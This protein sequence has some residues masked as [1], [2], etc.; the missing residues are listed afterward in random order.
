[1]R[2]PRCERSLKIT[3]YYMMQCLLRVITLRTKSYYHDL[4]DELLIIKCWCSKAKFYV[5]RST[6]GLAQT[7]Q[8]SLYI[9]PTTTLQPQPQIINH[10][11]YNCRLEAC[12]KK[13][14]N[15]NFYMTYSY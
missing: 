15:Q 2:R 12:E 3:L 10:K 1:V 9:A 14:I 6:V 7:R 13:P 4:L 5:L 11:R 8:K